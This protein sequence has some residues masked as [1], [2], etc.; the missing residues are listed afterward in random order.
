MKKS[1]LK[2]AIAS[3]V[4][5]PL[6][7]T[8]CLM[9][10][11]A[12]EVP[13]EI[14]VAAD[15]AVTTHLTAD[16]FTYIPKDKLESNWN[17]VFSGILLMQQDFTRPL[18]P[19]V[20]SDFVVANA[21]RYKDFAARV[22]TKLKD[23]TVS[24]TLGGG[25]VVKGHVDD[26]GNIIAEEVQQRVDV[27]IAD[28]IKEYGD[29][30]DFSPIQHIDFSSVH[31]SADVEITVDPA[32]IAGN[33]TANLSY[34]IVADDGNTYT[35]EGENSF[36]NYVSDK[37]QEVRAA[38]VAANDK[39]FV[40]VR[41]RLDE[42]QVKLKDAKAKLAEAK[43]KLDEAEA[44]GVNVDEA[45]ADYEAKK[46][47]LADAEAQLNQA[48]IDYKDAGGDADSKLNKILAGYD[49]KI[50]KA[51]DMYAKG[52]E[53]VGNVHAKGTSLEDALS[54]YKDEYTAKF[55][56][57]YPNAYDRLEKHLNKIP[58]SAS[59]AVNKK[60]VKKFYNSIMESV[61]DMI[62]ESVE[63][64]VNLDELAAI[65]DN[66]YNVSIDTDDTTGTIVGY[67][68]DDQ[69]A[70]VAAYYKEQGKE[71]VSSVKEVTAKFPTSGEGNIYYNVKRIIEL[72]DIE[73]T[74][75]TTVT[76]TNSE[77]TVTTVT[78]DSETGS[79]TTVTTVTSDS[80]T[81]SD[82]TVTTVT[83]GSGTGTETTA[84][85][86]SDTGT[87]TTV[88]TVTSGSGSG[89]GTE[90][91]ASTGSDTGTET[92]VTTVTSGSGTGTETTVSTGSDTGTETTVTTVTSGSGTGTET[93]VSTATSGSGT[94]TETTVSTATSG[95]GTGTGT[96][97]TTVTSGSGT[98]TETTVYAYKV[99]VEGD[100]FYYSHDD[101]N[102]SDK[103]GFSV[104][105]VNDDG[106]ETPLSADEYTLNFNTPVAA[107]ESKS[108][109]VNWTLN[110]FKYEIY[111][112]VGD[113]ESSRAIVYIG[114]KGDADLDNIVN[115]SDSTS[116]LK[117]YA[118]H[119]AD[120]DDPLYSE[121]NPLYE[122][123]AL[124]LAETD[125]DG[126]IN[127]SDSSNV[128]NYYA[129]HSANKLKT[130]ADIKAFWQEF[131]PAKTEE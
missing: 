14:A 117:Y 21:G 82:T 50:N 114:R 17:D 43:D 104:V 109:I 85:T 2:R 93:T 128:L 49:D 107:F 55:N 13:T 97:V 98:G 129:Q 8:Q 84:S 54:K 1:F 72:K 86:G 110:D 89:T 100:G 80:E 67:M 120:K 75:T 90:T 92:T 77:T 116:I 79:D 31:A 52:L 36:I 127:S 46:A 6:A 47:E 74:T 102:F 3:A 113:E 34:K 125:G 71:V 12:V 108:D 95:S 70:E 58:T 119:S 59:N 40:D 24:Y 37:Y 66:L 29:N 28:V 103:E 9:P 101:E 48:E 69:L 78:S 42:A 105:A 61:K 124:F 33:K 51:V 123:F 118:A 4:A 11:L 87:E 5:V 57:K 44:N 22:C 96:T 111:A 121:A 56:K 65:F 23:T 94:G 18:D 19:T 27:V 10:V 64:D 53:K 39:V 83:S 76:T 63:V 73:S 60:G 130:Q 20:V 45:K 41:A 91:T 25:L 15:T 7:L 99:V 106:T 115:S 88:T 26:V 122:S 131:L 68:K 62:P 32:G 16:S 38:V 81:S 35:I 126:I 112:T 30:V